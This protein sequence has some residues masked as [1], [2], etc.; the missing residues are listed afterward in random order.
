MRNLLVGVVALLLGCGVALALHR[1][2]LSLT[3]WALRGVAYDRV[4]AV[5]GW[6]FIG[7][8]VMMGAA[9]LCVGLIWVAGRE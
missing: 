3:V 4:L 2:W 9:L 8:P 1:M 5:C 7:I 6:V